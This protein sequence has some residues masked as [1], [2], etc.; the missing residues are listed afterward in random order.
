MTHKEFKS[1]VSK[2]FWRTTKKETHCY[3]TMML[4]I[5]LLILESIKFEKKF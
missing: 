3:A 5:N 1:F 2:F 4:Q